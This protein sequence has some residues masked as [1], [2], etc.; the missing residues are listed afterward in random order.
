MSLPRAHESDVPLSGETEDSTPNRQPEPL[1]KQVISRL[2]LAAVTIAL[3]SLAVRASVL[4]DAY[5]I[6]D[7]YMLMSRAIETDLTFDYL[8]RVHTGHF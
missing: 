2:A 8:T 4:R 5:F 1:E 7:D 6:T 3:L